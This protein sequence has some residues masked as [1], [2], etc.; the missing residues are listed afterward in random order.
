MMPFITAILRRW[1]H[2]RKSQAAGLAAVQDQVQQLR[3]DVKS[4][5]PIAAQVAEVL[6]SF[7]DEISFYEQQAKAHNLPLYKKNGGADRT[8]TG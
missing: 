6:N 4:Q 7:R 5:E 1:A 3:E 8:R 2:K